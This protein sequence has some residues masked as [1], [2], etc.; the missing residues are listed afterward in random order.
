LARRRPREDVRIRQTEIGAIEKIEELG[1]PRD[2]IDAPLGPS[3][4]W[5]TNG[6][7]NISNDHHFLNKMGF[8]DRRKRASIFI[9]ST[10]G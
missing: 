10:I 7:C 8:R 1:S 2:E 4:G 3:V 5:A 6:I 9:V